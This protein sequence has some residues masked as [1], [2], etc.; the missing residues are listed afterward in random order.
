MKI[1]GDADTKTLVQFNNYNASS[2]GSQFLFK[3]LDDAILLAAVLT[4]TLYWGASSIR[5]D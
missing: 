5:S 1:F 3:F 2:V 4:S